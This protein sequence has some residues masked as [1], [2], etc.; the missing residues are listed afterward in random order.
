MADDDLLFEFLRTED[1][2]ANNRT[3]EYANFIPLKNLCGK[4]SGKVLN[5]NFHIIMLCFIC[6]TQERMHLDSC[7][8]GL[9][10]S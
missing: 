6:C 7:L 4:N 5:N 2:S 8:L 3:A 9:H 10:S 1:I